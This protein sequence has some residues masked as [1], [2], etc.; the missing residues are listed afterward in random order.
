LTRVGFTLVAP[1]TYTLNLKTHQ[2]QKMV[3]ITYTLL[4]P[5]RARCTKSLRRIVCLAP[6]GAHTTPLGEPG[7][8]EKPNKP[9]ISHTGVGVGVGV[10]AAAISTIWPTQTHSDVEHVWG[11]FGLHHPSSLL[12]ASS[13]WAIVTNSGNHPPV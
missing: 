3:P 7:P 4:D 12:L 10:G 2:I 11:D 13:L 1:I 6:A 5:P 9:G 8:Q